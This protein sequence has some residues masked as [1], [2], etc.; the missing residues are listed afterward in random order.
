MELLAAGVYDL[1][2]TVAEFSELTPRHIDALYKRHLAA[3]T[4]RMMLT[5]WYANVHR[6]TDAHPDPFVMSDFV[7]IPP[8]PVAVVA[9]RSVMK[10]EAFIAEAQEKGIKSPIRRWVPNG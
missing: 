9:E 3:E 10:F 8:E 4:R 2:L 1:G 6:D 5:L 7:P